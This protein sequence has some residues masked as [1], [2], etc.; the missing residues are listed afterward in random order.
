MLVGNL[1]F[2]S[3]DCRHTNMAKHL[4][5]HPV[6]NLGEQPRVKDMVWMEEPD[7]DALPGSID[8]DGY[9]SQVEKPFQ[10]GHQACG[11][12][13]SAFLTGIASSD[14]RHGVLLVDLSVHVGDMVKAVVNGA[15]SR[16]MMCGSL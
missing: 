14:S 5:K 6:I 16:P 4:I 3:E 15:F 13:L 9:V 12:I 7:I 11:K 1:V 2:A 10:I 8:T